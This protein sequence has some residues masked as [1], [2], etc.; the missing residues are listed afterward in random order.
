MIYPDYDF[1][2]PNSSQVPSTFP[3]IHLH[4]L[5]SLSLESKQEEKEPKE[6]HAHKNYIKAQN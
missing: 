3:P 6:T 2:F 5:L 4:V 1:S